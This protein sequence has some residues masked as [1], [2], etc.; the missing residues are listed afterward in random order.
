MKEYYLKLLDF[1]IWA[2][3]N[4][5]NAILEHASDDQRLSDLY[6]H[7]ILAQEIWVNRILARGKTTHPWETIDM[8]SDRDKEAIILWMSVI[9]ERELDEVISYANTKGT[10]Y[11]STIADI[12]THLQMHSAYHRGQIIARLKEFTKDV[13]WV[14]YIAMLRSVT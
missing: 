11:E 2:N 6:S 5:K 4:V 7:I 3:E 13:P 12:L 14:D 1:E 10:A 9:D 8:Q